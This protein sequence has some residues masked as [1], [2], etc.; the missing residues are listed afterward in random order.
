MIRKPDLLT[1]EIILVGAGP[2]NSGLLTLRALKVLQEADVV[3]YDRLV[4]SEILEFIRRDAKRIYVGK[5][6]CEKNITQD[7][8]I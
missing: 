7:K 1:G 6:V 4:S 3:L 5:T 2:G 8:I